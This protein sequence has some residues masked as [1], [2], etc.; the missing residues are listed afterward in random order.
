[1]I[2]GFRLPLLLPLIVEAI[3][4]IA[5]FPTWVLVVAAY[6]VVPVAWGKK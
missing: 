2:M 4:G 5:M 6:G 3:P 1:M